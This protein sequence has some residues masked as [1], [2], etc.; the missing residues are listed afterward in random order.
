MGNGDQCEVKIARKW[1]GGQ[2]GQFAIKLIPRYILGPDSPSQRKLDTQIDIL[3][4]LEHPNIVRLHECTWTERHIGIVLEF[5]SGGRLGDYVHQQ[6]FLKDNP[7]RRLF[8]QLIS[9]VG[10]LHK[11]GVVHRN[12]RLDNV[13]LDRNRNIVIAGFRLAKTFNP[14]DEIGEGV[15]RRLNDPDYFDRMDVGI[16][17][18]EGHRRGDFEPTNRGLTYYT[19]P[20]FM[21]S[22]AR[23]TGRKA[24]VWSCGVIL[25]RKAYFP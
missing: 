1:C 16:I 23:Y 25:V 6:S 19:A 5:A 24:D 12:L 21:A 9:G 14:N 13:L 11:M 10:Y 2:F 18:E 7:A 22:G 4:G 17:D 8:A 15:E 20:E 3:C